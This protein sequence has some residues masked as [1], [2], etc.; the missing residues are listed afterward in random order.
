MGIPM[1]VP[2]G[3]LDNKPPHGSPCNNCGACCKVTVCDLGQHVFKRP[4]FTGEPCPGLVKNLDGTYGCGLVLYTE[5]F[6]SK[7][8]WLKYG[9]A[10]R[11]AALLLIGAGDGCDARFNGEWRNEVFA[12]ELDRRWASGERV[13]AAR[14]A[15]R[16]WGARS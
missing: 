5:A 10:L 2:R 4:E 8:R 11:R 16:M 9:Q 3:T 13:A 7:A 12:A 15:K 1:F 6:V 14:H